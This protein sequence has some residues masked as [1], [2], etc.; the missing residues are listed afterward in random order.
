MDHQHY[1]DVNERV[2]IIRDGECTMGVCGADAACKPFTNNTYT[3]LCPHDSLP[4]TK[5]QRCPNRITVPLDPRPIEN[6]LPPQNN[7]T[8]KGA[9]KTPKLLTNATES[10]I[11]VVEPT[12]APVTEADSQGVQY[13]TG[14][15]GVVFISLVI[16][17]II[18]K[19]LKHLSMR[20]KSSKSPSPIV[21]KR[22]LLVADRYAPNPQYSACSSGP[23]LLLRQEN[24]ELLKEI[25]EGCFG[26]VYKGELTNQYTNNVDVVAIK[27]LKESAT[28]EAEE[29]FLR[30]VDIMSAFK[31][32]NILSLLGVV[33]RGE[34]V[35]SPIMVFEYMPYGDLAEVL[36][37]QKSRP[38]PNDQPVPVL[39][40]KDLLSMALQVAAGMKYLAAQR[41]VHR[42]LACRNCLVADGPVV[43]IADFG[44][45]RD[46][47]TCDYYKIGGS[48]LLPVRWMSPESVLYGRF[49]LES[50]IWSY[51]IVLWEIFSYG[52]QPY[53]GHN[54]EEVVK[55]ILD[56]VT[57]LPPD[58]CPSVISD[59]MGYCWKAEPRDRIRFTEIYD[60][61]ENLGDDYDNFIFN[62]DVGAGDT[63]A[64]DIFRVENE[65][66]DS[67]KRLPRPPPLISMMI[68]P[69]D[70]D[71]DFE[72]Y[73]VPNQ[74][75]EPVQYLETLP[76]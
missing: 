14:T 31:H 4:P 25:G 30:E 11:Y 2:H 53:Y 52:R 22:N 39:T 48:R 57:L 23:V 68:Y 76:G 54:N 6:I 36:R 70:D 72:D 35:A 20:N 49:T 18:C 38:G 75:K 47:Y 12:V 73:L 64:E 16:I 7:D 27:V 44:M 50:D 59:L 46:V 71:L 24:L 15:V 5:D 26:K 62:G 58:D 3:C 61:L 55:L 10:T 40:T 29:D 28:Q 13:I 41:F 51:G 60:K 69:E 37:K 1:S 42:D 65:C 56:A 74:I 21:L 45:S 43:K 67:L 63:V 33:Q 66:G 19:L 17:V 32:K 9:A 8:T 34:A